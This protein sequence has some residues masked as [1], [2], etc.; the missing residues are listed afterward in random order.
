MLRLKA[1][2]NS[3]CSE[4]W[5]NLEADIALALNKAFGLNIMLVSPSRL[6]TRVAMRLRCILGLA[7]MAALSCG[8]ENPRFVEVR[9]TTMGT[10]WSVKAASTSADVS[11]SVLETLVRDQL[12]LVD[13]LMST[14]RDDSELSRFNASLETEPFHIAPQTAR[15]LQHALDVGDLTRGAFDV[16]VGPL[17]NAW[18]FGAGGV[19]TRTP[20]DLEITQLL[21][22]TGQEHLR[23]DPLVPT[24]TKSIASLGIDLSAVGKGFAVDLVAENLIEHGFMS[25]LVEVGGEIRVR[26]TNSEGGPWRLA[27]ERPQIVG[28][29]FQKV[30]LLRD[31]S[32][33]TSGD[34]RNYREVAGIRISHI[35]DPRIGRPINHRLVS[36]SV[37]DALCV[38]AD[39]FATALLVLGP[40]DGFALAEELGLAALFL[41]R[42]EDGEFEER[43]TAHFRTLSVVSD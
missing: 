31:G 25:F 27:V 39:A 15:V 41:L 42:D 14:Y 10:T 26:G 33:A 17:V 13:E 18:G 8:G 22:S 12:E 11:S 3:T 4:F 1:Y 24:V 7:L 9:G 16:T 21:R 6:D 40:D 2:E 29:S 35:I 5:A 19:P 20:S 28:R 43:M 38:R 36:V 30:L 23:L 34:Y 32:L 37:I